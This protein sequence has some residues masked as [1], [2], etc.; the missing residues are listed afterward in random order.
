MLRLS[1]IGHVIVT[2]NYC[3]FHTVGREF[4]RVIIYFLDS[5]FKYFKLQVRGS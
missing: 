2:W 4:F 3:V 1:K 5:Y